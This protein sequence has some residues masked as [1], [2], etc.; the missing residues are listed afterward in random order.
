MS[1]APRQQRI[2]LYFEV[3]SS[4][5]R[6]ADLVQFLHRLRQRLRRRIILVMDR[7]PVHFAAVRRLHEEGCAWLE[8]EWLP[9]Y[10]PELNPVEQMWGHAK[11][12]DLANF[13]PDSPQE[14]EDAVTESLCDQYG[15]HDLKRT[16]FRTAGLSL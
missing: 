4:N 1:L 12:S 11:Y 9:P 10:A 3:Q 6:T 5:V 14:L 16:F 8:V 15:E 7:W 2:G 13:V